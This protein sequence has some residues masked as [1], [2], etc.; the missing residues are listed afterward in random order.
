MIKM[1]QP[2]NVVESGFSYRWNRT[3]KRIFISW[4]NFISLQNNVS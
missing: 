1:I 4:I 2:E 3:W